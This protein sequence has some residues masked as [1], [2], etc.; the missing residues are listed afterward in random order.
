MPS[1]DAEIRRLGERLLIKTR[2]IDTRT[3]VLAAEVIPGIPGQ[4]PV[5]IK[6]VDAKTR[7]PV[8]TLEV[9]T[10]LVAT[11]RMP[12]TA[13][14]GLQHQGIQTDR[15]FVPV[16]DHMRVLTHAA[17]AQV[18]FVIITTVTTVKVMM[19]QQYCVIVPIN[20]YLQSQ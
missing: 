4:R 6:M 15:G 11:G 8:E 7:T 12:N 1:F 19:S 5:T 13:S 10:C 2:A 17:S 14:L 20:T 16:D 18:F 3:G 9:D